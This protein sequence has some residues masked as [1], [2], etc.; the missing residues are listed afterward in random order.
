MKFTGLITLQE[1]WPKNHIHDQYS[2]VSS[3]DLWT[4]KGHLSRNN[5]ILF[6]QTGLYKAI[7]MQ[8]EYS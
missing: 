6:F 5:I 7:Y 8:I 3:C 2:R 1:K 4:L